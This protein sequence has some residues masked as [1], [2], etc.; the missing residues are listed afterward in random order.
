MEVF[1]F[2]EKKNTTIIIKQKF[3]KINEPAA[4]LLFHWHYSI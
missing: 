1:G 2:Y 4:A 3:D